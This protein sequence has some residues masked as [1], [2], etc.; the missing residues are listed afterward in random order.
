MSTLDPRTRAELADVAA[1]A[2]AAWRADEEE[3]TAAALA[4][5]H[6]G[7]TLVDVAREHLHRG[8]TIT[9]SWA[10]ATTRLTGV[11]MGVGADVVALSVGSTRVDLALHAH[12]PI[13]WR[14]AQRA[15]DGGSRGH[16]LNG[17]RARLLELEA[18][19]D[20]VDVGLDDEVVV[21]RLTV[22]R[23]HVVVVDD[24]LTTV[25]AI[26]A[27]RYVRPSSPR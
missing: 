5:W 27:L 14:V 19:A 22:G 4:Q 3:W 13:V 18:A 16:A 23:D 8:D 15:H 26:S 10:G 12:T 21:G 17:F 20:V 2:R 24:D 6:H 9:V 1:D 25:V 7:R 11:V